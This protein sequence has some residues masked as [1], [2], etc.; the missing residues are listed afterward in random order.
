MH[1]PDQT[2]LYGLTQQSVALEQ[3]IER[4]EHYLAHLRAERGRLAERMVDA[5]REA[6]EQ[7]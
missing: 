5:R 1:D 6:G 3:E 4:V 7:R 2:F